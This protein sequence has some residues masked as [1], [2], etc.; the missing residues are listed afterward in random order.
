MTLMKEL[1]YH[2]SLK[3]TLPLPLP[4]ISAL[5]EHRKLRPV[6]LALDD[7]VSWQTHQSSPYSSGKSICPRHVR[8][9]VSRRKHTA[10]QAP[11]QQVFH[12]HPDSR[13]VHGPHG[14]RHRHNRRRA[15][16][17]SI[18]AVAARDMVR[19]VKTA[20]RVQGEPGKELR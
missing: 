1:S 20:T 7:G 9:A 5:T 2:D 4:P 10:L 11:K 3:R 19:A 18:P 13:R 12:S 14:S 16:L 17:P 15:V 6:L 8:E